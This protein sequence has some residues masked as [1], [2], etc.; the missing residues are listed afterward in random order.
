MFQAGT[1]IA[2][3]AS[4]LS[5]GWSNDGVFQA[6]LELLLL[7]L[8]VG[9]MVGVPGVAGA[10]FALPSGCT[11]HSALHHQRICWL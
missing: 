6:L 2:G 11:L 4:A 9:A 7:F 3:A 5:S 8:L 1:S 10:A